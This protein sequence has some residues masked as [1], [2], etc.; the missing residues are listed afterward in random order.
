MGEAQRLQYLLC[1]EVAARLL[2]AGL[3]VF[4]IQASAFAIQERGRL[5]DFSY[6]A[7][8]GL[9]AQG[10]VPLLYG[11]PAVD[12]AQGCSILSGDV[13]ATNVAAR[14]GIPL[15][16]HATLTDGVF[17]A[18]PASHP[19]AQRIA[20]I[21][22]SNWETVRNA[23][24]TSAAIDVTGGMAAKIQALLDLAQA[25]PR[26]RIVSAQ[27]AGRITDAIQGRDVGTLV[28]WEST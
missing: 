23:V 28:C 6:A 15:L 21:D 8:E 19:E 4:P 1:A 3:P 13:I 17:E 9:V 5:V 12:R 7:I 10:L 2:D 25:G 16:I 14:L 20:R 26:S 11:V 22:R 18:D 24:G 27:I